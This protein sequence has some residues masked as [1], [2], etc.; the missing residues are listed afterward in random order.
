MRNQIYLSNFTTT[1]H[2]QWLFNAK[3]QNFYRLVIAVSG[4]EARSIHW[5]SKTLE[6]LPKSEKIQYSVAGFSKYNNILSRPKNDNFYESN[7]ILTQP[8][9]S[10]EWNDFERAIQPEIDR[11]KEKAKE[12]PIEI[13]VDYSCMPRRWYCRLPFL[14]EKQLRP[15]DFAY[16]WYSP[17]EYPETE[18][19]TAAV[20]DFHIFS[21]KPNL[22]PDFRTHIFGLG[23]DRIRSQAIWSVI[24]PENLIC[25][26]TDPG[27]V[28]GYVERVKK[29]NK[30]ILL[31]ANY[32]FSV[33]M[34]DFVGTLSKLVGI[35][36]EFSNV[37]DVI[38]VPDGPKPLILA[39]SL[40]PS[41]LNTNGIVCFHVTRRKMHEYKP[42]EVD[43]AG[44]PYGFSFQGVPVE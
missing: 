37:G 20:E 25:F 10:D 15:V 28:H 22:N 40:I 11:I 27:T 9:P 6:I 5:I 44:E 3:H 21:G 42:I 33:P 32:I 13:H 24:D 14:I 30:E 36:R 12:D 2:K 1:I 17:G 19:P 39:S 29:D 38:L 41:F 18:Y 31:A 26:Y 43:P 23:F 8:L 16:F 7:H 34:Q 35:V 4:Y